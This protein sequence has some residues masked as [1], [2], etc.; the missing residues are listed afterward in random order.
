MEFFL[1]THSL[2]NV[3]LCLIRNTPKPPK[4]AYD[5][6]RKTTAREPRG[7]KR[8]NERSTG[9]HPRRR[10]RSG[11]ADRPGDE[12]NHLGEIH[13]VWWRAAAM[14]ICRC[15]KHTLSFVGTQHQVTNERILA[16]LFG[17]LMCERSLRNP[18]KPIPRKCETLNLYMNNHH[19][20]NTMYQ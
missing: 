3:H 4:L 17:Y 13:D 19:N 18:K 6:G 7:P 10:E 14:V 8:R 1:P 11:I 9:A 20:N 16:R 5:V 12:R 2:I 15:G